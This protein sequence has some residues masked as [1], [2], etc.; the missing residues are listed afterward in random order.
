MAQP[1]D[2]RKLNVVGEP[3]PIAQDLGT[4]ISRAYFSVSGNGILAYRTGSGASNQLVW[5]DR[6]GRVLGNAG[7]A[8]NYEE[9]A[10]SPDAS[11]VVHSRTTN[12]GGE[13]WVLDI[14]R[15]IPSRLTLDP[16]GSRSPVWSPDGK[17]VVYATLGGSGAL[18]V[19]PAGSIGAERLL[20]Q[21]RLGKF[22]NHWSRDGRFL[23]YT[24]VS[25]KTGMDLYALAD[26]LSPGEHK[27]IP[28]VVTEFSESQGQFCPDGH[29]LAYC[30]SE[31]G[32]Y[33]V[34][35]RPFPTDDART[36]KWMVS[37]NGGM[38]PRWRADGK[39]LF[40]VSPDRKLMAVDTKT[41][42]SFEAGAPHV[43][44]ESPL[45]LPAQALFRYDVTPDGQR[46][47]MILPTT[48]V[49]SAAATVMMN[50]ESALKN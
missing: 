9:L 29:W 37:S 6:S 47:L 19:K 45:F 15:S 2:E 30:S 22:A 4:S 3:V 48:G 33:D 49:G 1:F 16:L 8:G 24:E 35:V 36:G 13:I 21:S 38:Q 25:T 42:P 10:L 17:Y 43:L 20:F 32:R 34:Y 18:K 12:G 39:E 7:E 11:R 41:G 14:A 5:H 27:P 28:L 26:P 46:F 44:F 31:S 40:Y 23:V 50:W